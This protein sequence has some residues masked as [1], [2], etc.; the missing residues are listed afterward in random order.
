MVFVL[1]LGR[2]W[3]NLW[4]QLTL[5]VLHSSGLC[6]ESTSHFIDEQLDPRA[7]AISPDNSFIAVSFGTRIHL[8]NYQGCHRQWGTLLIIPA[9]TTLADVK[10]QV[11]NFS[12]D[13]T[14]LVVAT[15][16]HDIFRSADDDTISTYV[17]KCTRSP[18]QPQKMGTCKMPTVSPLLFRLQTFPSSTNVAPSPIRMGKA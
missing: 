8:F 11:V 16:R 3:A 2:Y 4:Q 9:F 12:S 1:E 18:P 6:E 15:Q 14:A 5:L 10:F 13:N 17:W 7:L